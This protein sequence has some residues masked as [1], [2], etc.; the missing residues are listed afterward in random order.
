MAKIFLR[1]PVLLNPVQWVGG[2]KVH[3]HE[4]YR[5]LAYNQSAV[6]SN[7]FVR[8]LLE[9][10]ADGSGSKFV[11]G[12]VI[13]LTVE[14]SPALESQGMNSQASDHLLIAESSSVV[15][16]TSK[17]KRLDSRLSKIDRKPKYWIIPIINQAVT[18]DKYYFTS[19]YIINNSKY[20]EYVASDRG[21]SLRFFPRK[22]A[23][24]NGNMRGETCFIPDA[25]QVVENLYKSSI[26][27]L[28]KCVGEGD[29]RPT[30]G[31]VLSTLGPM[32][33][34]V[35]SIPKVN[36]KLLIDDI[37]ISS[38]MFIPYEKNPDLCEQILLLA[39]YKS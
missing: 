24:T 15:D 3:S 25:P 12:E 39:N 27:L 13:E 5:A 34:F 11:N 32:F 2:A 16:S 36:L 33:Q 37:Q 1:H 22:L 8:G 10:K 35:D 28:F 23:A 18:L 31:M 20:V 14:K 38:D 9:L 26:K 30:T 6:D 19:H 17:A 4:L 7:P 21:K 29:P